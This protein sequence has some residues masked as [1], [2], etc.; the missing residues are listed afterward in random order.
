[1][2][3]SHY[4]L[5][6]LG[7]LLFILPLTQRMLGEKTYGRREIRKQAVNRRLNSCRWVVAHFCTAFNHI[8]ISN[9]IVIPVS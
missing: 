6:K 3:W 2:K 8:F 9:V 4:F 5:S 7:V 1:M